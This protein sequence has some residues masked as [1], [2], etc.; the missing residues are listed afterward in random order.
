MKLYLAD[1]AL[2]RLKKMVDFSAASFILGFSCDEDSAAKLFMKILS[3]GRQTNLGNPY[4]SRVLRWAF[5]EVLP[6]IHPASKGITEGSPELKREILDLTAVQTRTGRIRAACTYTAARNTPF[7]GL[8]ADGAKIALY[9]L[10]QAGY[11]VS[12]FI[13][14]EFVIE[15]P[16]RD[17]VGDQARTVESIV[18]AAMRQVVPDVAVRTE[19]FITERWQKG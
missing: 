16:D 13:H 14:D 8:A 9:C 5:D 11:R 15:L 12:N 18:V 7:Q 19:W 1:D 4:S 10:Q 17:G 3:G 2:T 6:K